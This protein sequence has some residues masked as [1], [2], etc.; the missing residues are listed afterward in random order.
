MSK[1]KV[2]CV[3]SMGM[4][5]S[6]YLA[7]YL[8]RKGYNTR[9]G[10]I[11]PCKFDPEPKNPLKKEDIEWADI[12]ITARDKHKPILVNDYGVKNKKIIVLNVRDSR[13]AMSKIYP[14]FNKIDQKDFNKKWTYPQ[15]RKSI[16]PYLP[17]KK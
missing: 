9:Y 7:G 15:L 1:L 6:K 12:I 3:C 10:G 5:R 8:K 4:N 16:K 17:L 11:G 13:F 2:L 14:E